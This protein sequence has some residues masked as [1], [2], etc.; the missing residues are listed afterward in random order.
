[1]RVVIGTQLV[2]AAIAVL[3]AGLY[4]GRAGALAA[5]F[6]AILGILVTWLTKRSSERVL[7]AAVEDHSFGL[8]AMYVGFALKY[9]VTVLGLLIGFR[10]LQLTAA[11]MVSVF[12][13]MILAQV[14]CSP[15][16]K[17]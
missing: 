8:V 11:P 12:I 13:L 16:I 9:A 5:L 10:V 4:L 2:L 1:M 3:L 14:F 7:R 17:A 6:G 15:W